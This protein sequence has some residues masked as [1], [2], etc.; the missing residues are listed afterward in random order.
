MKKIHE[1]KN[2]KKFN[3][4]INKVHEEMEFAKNVVVNWN[5][6]WNE[7]LSNAYCY[8]LQYLTEDEIAWLESIYENRYD[9]TNGGDEKKRVGAA[10]AR[11]TLVDDNDEEYVCEFRN[12][13]WNLINSKI[14]R[15]FKFYNTGD[16]EYSQ[17]KRNRKYNDDS[18]DYYTKY[19][20][21]DNSLAVRFVRSNEDLS[22]YYEGSKRVISSDGVVLSENHE[23][24]ELSFS[25]G[26]DK[27]IVTFDEQNRIDSKVLISGAEVFIICGNEVVKATKKQDEEEIELEITEDLISRVNEKL[28][29]LQIG[30]FNK[31]E[32][33]TLVSNMKMRLMN[34]IK[35]VKSDTPLNG[36]M[37]R[38]D[39]LLSMIN[40]KSN[41][42]Q[43][44]DKKSKSKKKN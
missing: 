23:G 26:E 25:N 14:A 5:V 31:Y 6:K 11:E 8:D 3:A 35:S 40:A 33:L 34:A 38:F 41:T 18:Y 17:V 4:T 28:F 44:V 36:L 15:I 37:R 16:I 27:V 43:I 24:M 30:N 32:L 39:I 7:V 13:T 1:S 12:V 2:S 22:V 19:N 29:E 42:T 20:V 21:N 10:L 9:L